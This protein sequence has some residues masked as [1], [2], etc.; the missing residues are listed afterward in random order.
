MK[1][2]LKCIAVFGVISVGLAGEAATESQAMIAPSGAGVITSSVIAHES[3]VGQLP[4]SHDSMAWEDII[5]TYP[6][7][8]D[9][10][11]F[12]A[13][14][15]RVV[16][17]DAR[18]LDLYSRDV[19]VMTLAYNEAGNALVV[20]NRTHPGFAADLITFESSVPEQS[21]N[22]IVESLEFVMSSCEAVQSEI[23]QVPESEH[24]QAQTPEQTQVQTKAHEQ[25]QASKEMPVNEE[26]KECVSIVAR[27]V[28]QPVPVKQESQKEQAQEPV[29]NSPS[30]SEV[31]TERNVPVQEQK[32]K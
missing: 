16:E 24:E 15:D 29:L 10:I 18:T 27:L 28:L 7:L 11:G 1:N 30:S 3:G 8:A 13:S 6:Q 9:R 22:S 12:L 31:G 32:Q 2:F 21:Q 17:T 14:I 4:A 5:A 23:P 25:T 26:Q 19:I 20:K